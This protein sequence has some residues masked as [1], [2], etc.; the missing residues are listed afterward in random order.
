M[1]APHKATLREMTNAAIKNAQRETDEK[2]KRIFDEAL[3]LLK[4]E[5]EAGRSFATVM[6]LKAGNDFDAAAMRNHTIKP[7]DLQGVAARIYNQCKVFEPTLEYWTREEGCQRDSYTVEGFNLVIHWS[8]SDDLVRRVEQLGDSALTATIRRTI[9]LVD[10][11]V[12]DKAMTI[13]AQLDARAT[14]QAKSGKDW[15]IVMALKNGVDFVRPA[16]ASSKSCKPEWLGPVA[17]AVWDACAD[18][19]PTLEYWSH[20]AGDWRD[21][22]T[23]EGFNIVI[24][25]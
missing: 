11:A 4:V 14:S 5:V 8:D 7:E 23:E 21:R 16:G 3:R 13:I 12:T 15:A 6:S 10:K 2:A 19:A 18:L 17:K 22:W 9:E 25:W 20:D 24:H 1:S